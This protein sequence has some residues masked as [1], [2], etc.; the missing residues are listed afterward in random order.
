[1]AQIKKHSY[2]TEVSIDWLLNFPAY[3]QHF[4]D[5]RNEVI[6]DLLQSA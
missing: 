2:Y 6:A 3:C 5:D 1:M 4:E